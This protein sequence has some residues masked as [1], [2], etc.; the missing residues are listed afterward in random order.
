MVETSVCVLW[1]L[2]LTLNLQVED[3]LVRAEAVTGHTRVVPRILCFDGAD[4]KAAVPMDAASA[5]DHN[6]RWR[7]VAGTQTRFR[8]QKQLQPLLEAGHGRSRCDC[9]VWTGLTALSAT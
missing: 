3:D 6:R 9:G 8:S 7:P 5:V 1:L 2:L 4:D